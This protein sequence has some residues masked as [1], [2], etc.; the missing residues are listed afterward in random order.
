[1]LRSLAAAGAVGDVLCHF[2]D[3][4]GCVVDHPVNRRVVAVGLEDLR[5]VPRIVLAAGGRRKAVAIRAALAATGARVL[6]TDAGA[7]RAMLAAG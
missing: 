1:M 3:A 7:A 2:V 4:D 6:V 5:K